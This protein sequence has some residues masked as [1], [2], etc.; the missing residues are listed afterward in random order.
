MYVTRSQPGFR[1][2]H[3]PHLTR[4]TCY[5]RPV[6]RVFRRRLCELVRSARLPV[7]RHQRQ[8]HLQLDVL[9]YEQR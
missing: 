3:V 8:Q 5:R 4:C 6:V 9:R 7:R 1:R 2:F